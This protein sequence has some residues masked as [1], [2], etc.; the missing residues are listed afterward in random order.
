M[1]CFLYSVNQCLKDSTG[2]FLRLPDMQS[3]RSADG[4]KTQ[5]S[6]YMNS[7]AYP[8]ALVWPIWVNIYGCSA[9]RIAGE[10]A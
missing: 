7:R 2:L 9:V 4:L 6:P 1:E 10:H 5:A 8:R 3:D